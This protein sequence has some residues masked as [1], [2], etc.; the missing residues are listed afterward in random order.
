[1]RIG[2]DLVPGHRRQRAAGHAVG[3][4][5]IVVPEPDAAHVIA[6]VAHEPRIAVG[7][8]GAGLAGDAHPVEDRAL[9]GA[10]L[11]DLVHHEDHLQGDLLR[12][13]L[14]GLLAVTVEAPHHLSVRAAHLEHGMRRHRFAEIRERGIGRGVVEH[15]HFIRSDR[16]RGRVGQRSAQPHFLR[17]LHRMEY[18]Q[19][20][21]AR[22]NADCHVAT[23]R[24]GFNLAREHQIKAVVIADR[25]DT[26][27]IY[28][29]R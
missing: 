14:L 10:F 6:R 26:R 7:V 24:E 22:R 28:R 5:V 15:R 21:A 16:E 19:R 11:H 1:M 27:C 12:D 20:I 4:I 25:C 9:A 29:E 8:G 3:R 2:H 17:R 23:V 13:H 18:V